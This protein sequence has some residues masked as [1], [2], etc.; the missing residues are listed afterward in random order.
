MKD[1]GSIKGILLLD[2]EAKDGNHR[3]IQKSIEKI[4]EH[5]NYAW[6]TLRVQEDT[7]IK[8]ESLLLRRFFDIV[9]QIP[10]GDSNIEKVLG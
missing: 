9:G 5:E 8:V 3:S 7:K 10:V 6:Q 1:N 4:V 2:R